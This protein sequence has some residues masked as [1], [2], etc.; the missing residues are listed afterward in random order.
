MHELIL[1]KKTLASVNAYLGRA[2][3]NA[4]TIGVIFK[5][6]EVGY[7]TSDNASLSSRFDIGSISKTFTAQLILGLVSE[8]KLSLDDTADKFLAVKKGSYPTV[9]ELLT[10]TA[11]YGHLTPVEITLPRLL[12][13]RY[14]RANLYR[15]I[16]RDDVISALSRRNRTK[17]GNKY[18]YSVFAYAVLAMI[19][20]SVEKMPFYELMNELIKEKYRLSDSEAY[21]TAPRVN[22]YLG[23]KQIEAWEWDPENPYIAGGGIVSTVEDM[24]KYADLQLKSQSDAILLAQKIHSGSFS[25]HSNIGTC[26]GWHTYKRSNQLWHVGG[27]GAFRSSMVINRSLK[28]AVVVLGNAKGG[29]ST[30]VHYLAKL[31]YS[32]LKR[33]KIRLSDR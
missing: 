10:H 16:G 11:G 26:L 24:I 22:T 18:G 1:S 9:R 30:N 3:T 2:K 12:Q 5:S 7:F 13:K 27:V 32:E 33:K 28:C 29:R 19:A 25:E 4:L 14:I 21:P 17:H 23:K 8:G 6:G 15:G 31:I 20:E